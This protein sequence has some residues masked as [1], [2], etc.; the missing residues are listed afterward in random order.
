MVVPPLELPV[1]RLATYPMEIRHLT[2][3]DLKK[4]RIDSKTD[5]SADDSGNM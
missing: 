3:K 2:A 1:G 5:R 4:C